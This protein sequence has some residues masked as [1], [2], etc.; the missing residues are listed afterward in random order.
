MDYD[1]GPALMVTYAVL[2]GSYYKRVI[3]IGNEIVYKNGLFEKF[4]N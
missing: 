3:F 4:D 2:A 1:N